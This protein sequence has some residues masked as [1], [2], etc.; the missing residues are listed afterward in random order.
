MVH[1]GKFLII[2]GNSLL[3][4]AWHAIP[5]SL[6][7]K[8]GE[9]VNAVYG[10]TVLLLK[11]LKDIQPDFIAVTFDRKAPTFRHTEYAEYKAKRVKQPD[12]FYEQFPR[13]KELLAAFDIPV[14]EKD[15]FEA[16]DIIATLCEEVRK[17]HPGI[18]KIIMSGDL[19]LLQLVDGHTKI[20]TPKKGIS[21]TALYDPSAVRERFCGLN[22]DQMVDYKALRGDESDNIPGIKGIGEKIAC[23][24]I[25]TFG[26][27]KKVY[28]YIDATSEKEN[29]EQKKIKEAVFKKLKDQ[30]AGAELGYRLCTV[31][32][33]VPIEW[34]LDACALHIRDRSA[35]TNI[36]QELE[37]KSLIPRLKD[38]FGAPQQSLFDVPKKSDDTETGATKKEEQNTCR[39]LVEDKEIQDFLE[40]ISKQKECA[41]TIEGSSDDAR[42]AKLL[43]VSIWSEDE[44][45]AY[46]IPWKKEAVSWKKQF[47]AICENESIQKIGHNCK[48]DS[49]V[50]AS[51]NIHLNGIDFD[52]LLAAYLLNPGARE[53]AI[54]SLAFSEFGYQCVHRGALK[55]EKGKDRL[56]SELTEQELAEY[57]CEYTGLIWRLYQKQLEELV[58]TKQQKLLQNIEIPLI[59]TLI[60]MEENGVKLDTD[61]LSEL[62]THI[63]K[64]IDKVTQI[65]YGYAGKEFN[66]ASSLQLKE[67]LFDVLKI[68]PKRIRKGKTGLSTAAS[69]LEKMRPLHPII[70]YI[71]HYRELAKLQNT[72]VDALPLLID[73]KTGRVHTSFNQTITSTGRLS[74]SN[75]NL[76]NIPI[77]TELGREIRKCFIAEKGYTLLAVDYSQVEL[78]IIASLA[79][80]EKMI[81]TFTQGKDIHAL[82]AAE[83]H[84][85]T[86]EEVTKDMRR[87]AKEVNF[88]VIYGM[89]AQGLSES[90]G[91]SY[92]EAQDFIER[93][94]RAYPNVRAFLDETIRFGKKHGYAETL[95]GRRRYLPELTSHIPYIRAA[96]ERMA[97]NMPVQGSAADYMKLAMIAVFENVIRQ[98]NGGID[99]IQKKPIRMILQVHDELVFEVRGDILE[100]VIRQLKKEMESVA[101]LAVPLLVEC[102]SGKNWGEL[103]KIF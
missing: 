18:E 44:K 29:S 4:R 87:A 70:E 10:F 23:E 58:K 6:M 72:Y 83:I 69:E 41:Y 97:I 56:L 1:T 25:K 28:T 12:E 32:R 64:E 46:F 11:A 38:L 94:F 96:A 34:D 16:D 42:H 40:K 17:T 47:A 95:L 99:E 60:E 3:H 100:D 14:F 9:L 33:D 98:M 59:K 36:F 80:D 93:Y 90:A 48:Y 84:G 35:V 39:I 86:L 13:V 88:G 63:G 74:S 52:T 50:L 77:R 21:E 85:I 67:I 82:T 103:L 71:L 62:S 27:L 22:P 7:T 61:F 26:S 81:E 65:I 57:S 37:F 68:S 43:G 54:D 5:P 15:G 31:V 101:Q 66:I 73:K 20:M 78:R 53:Y 8:K 2:D 30:K 79:K 24:L 19:D 55:N 91:I 76:Q 51:E 92:G 45:S 102:S 75:P 49:I 89:G